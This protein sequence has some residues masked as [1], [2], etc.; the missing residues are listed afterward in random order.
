[1]R[2][3]ENLGLALRVLLGIA[4]LLL[5]AACS[6]PNDSAANNRAPSLGG[7]AHEVVLHR[8]NGAEVES[9]DPAL[10]DT[11]WEQWIIGDMLMGLFTED[12]EGN[13]ILGAAESAAVSPDG[14]TWTFTLRDSRWSDGT[15]VTAEDFVYAWRRTLDPQ[16][17]GKYGAILYV[18]KHAKD[19]AEGKLPP[20]ALGARA[21]GPR[22]LILELEHPASYLPELLAHN[23][24]YPVPRQLVETKGAAWTQPGNYI[25]NGP[26]V[27]AERVPNDHVTLTKN[28][29]FFD[30]GHVHIDRVVF[31]PTEDASGA[32]KRFRAGELDT[33]NPFPADQIDWL[34]ANMPAALRQTPTLAIDYVVFNERRKPFDDMRVREAFDLAFDRDVLA[35]K[36]Y[37]LGEEPAYSI[38]P[39]GIANYPGGA[40]LSFRNLSYP[41]RLARAQTLMRQAG[42]G[43]D[44]PLHT[45]YA[46]S[47]LGDARRAAVAIQAMWR[48]IYVDLEIVQSES[49][50]NYTK[51]REGDFDIGA[52]AWAADFNDASNFLMVLTT[53]NPQNYG[54]YSN[55]AFDVLYERAEQERDVEKRGQILLQAENIALN[56]HAWITRNFRANRTIVQPYVKGWVANARDM[57]R[58]RWLSID[59]GARAAARHP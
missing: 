16:T 40:A 34:R 5:A 23:I 30:A 2:V 1:M 35:N 9:L 33:Q 32:L 39:R 46:T 21:E 53:G 56:D 29:R 58:T 3:R 20:S 25:S 48:A 15:P 47:A 57:N 27:L 14:K 45:T 17:A 10:A 51:L 11:S 55:P 38:I 22:R 52:G 12:A 8:G 37:R 28:P 41:A 4:A 42:Y 6:D 31:Y 44:R 26:Y 18:F 13:A 50:V 43:P 7:S 19:I 24:T 54:G 36:I 49:Q 59:D